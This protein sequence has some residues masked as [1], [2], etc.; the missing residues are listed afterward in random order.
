VVGGSETVLLAEDDAMVCE[1]TRRVL[2]RAGYTV[3]Q[4]AD[5][6]EALAV[7]ERHADAIDVAVLDVIMPGLG[8]RQVYERILRIKPQVRVL[9]ASG[10]SMNAIH[11]NFVLDEGLTLIQKPYDRTTLLRKLRDVLD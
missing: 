5:G 2:E 3:L 11:T 7:F 6:E 9:F 10:Y 4:A 1:L 8:G